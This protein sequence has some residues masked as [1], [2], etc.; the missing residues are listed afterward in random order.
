MHFFPKLLAHFKKL[1][2]DTPSNLNSAQ[3][4]IIFGTDYLTHFVPNLKRLF[5]E[6][7]IKL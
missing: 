7:H 6:A 2:S 4:K 5:I 3:I 1:F